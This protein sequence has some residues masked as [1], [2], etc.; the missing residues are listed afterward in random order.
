MLEDCGVEWVLWDTRTPTRDRESNDIVQKNC[1][2]HSMPG[3]LPVLH[4]RTQEERESGR[5]LEVNPAQLAH[6]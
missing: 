4:R 3:S 6:A 5:Q 1:T 2:Q